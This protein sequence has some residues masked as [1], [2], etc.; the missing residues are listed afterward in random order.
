MLAL[1]SSSFVIRNQGAWFLVF[2]RNPRLPKTSDYP[3]S[4][5]M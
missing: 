4:A 2:L 3:R 1:D 5:T